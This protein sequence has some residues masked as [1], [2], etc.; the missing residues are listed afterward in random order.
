MKR[1]LPLLALALSMGC[2]TVYEP[3]GEKATPPPA[4]RTA[5]TLLNNTNVDLD[6][7]QDGRLV[8]TGLA[9]GQALPIS[10]PIFGGET[11]V[12]VTGY[13]ENRQYLGAASWTFLWNVPEA[14]IVGR[15]ASRDPRPA[16]YTW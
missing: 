16:A 11:I 4:R 15:V 6:V 8:F 10:V 1:L 14:W 7:I 3:Q 5:H 2:T 12:I 13:D 9:P